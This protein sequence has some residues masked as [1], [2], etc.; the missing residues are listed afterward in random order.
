M[1]DTPKSEEK[2]LMPK[3]IIMVGKKPV[4]SYAMAALM[5]LTDSGAITIKV[6]GRSIYALWMSQ[7]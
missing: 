3:D 7:R 2:P 6:R 4:M 5:Q 1:A